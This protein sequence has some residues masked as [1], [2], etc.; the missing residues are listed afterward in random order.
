MTNLDQVELD[1]ENVPEQ[2]ASLLIPISGNFLLLPNVSVA[3]ISELLPIDEWA[4]EPD[5]FL[6]YAE[7]R[8]VPVPVVSFELI[9]GESLGD[10]Y[11]PKR[12]AIF[13][14]VIGNEKLRFLAI[15]TQG[16]PR[17]TR[18]R[19]EEIVESDAPVG[20]IEYM[21]VTVNGEVAIIPNLEKLEEMILQQIS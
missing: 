1:A 3:E 21:R 18:V 14:N 2:I 6:G 11:Q 4:S 16:I 7:W 20:E 5:W 17:L 13:N 15:P 8:G 12:I 19:A 10:N 9:N